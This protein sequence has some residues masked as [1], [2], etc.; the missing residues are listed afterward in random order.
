MSQIY[1]RGDGGQIA[2]YQAGNRVAA[3]SLPHRRL[4]QTAVQ[5]RDCLEGLTSVLYQGRIYFAYCNLAHQVAMDAVG[6]GRE[7]IVLTEHQEESRF[8]GLILTVR[9]EQ[10]ML[11][12]QAWNP[13]REQF[14]L[15]LTAP[16]RSA[17]SRRVGDMGDAPGRC[18]LL[19]WQGE[20]FLLAEPENGENGRVFLWRSLWEWQ[21]I[22]WR[23]R[24]PMAQQ[25]ERE[26]FLQRR[27][28]ALEERESEQR[29]REAALRERELELQGR[30]AALGERESELQGREAALQEQ[31]AA[32]REPRQEYR[33]RLEELR[34]KYEAQ[35]DSARAQ[36]QDLADT[37]AQL[38]QIG[39]MWRDK[40][41]QMEG[42]ER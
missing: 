25:A 24:G 34:R 20:T 13:E 6:G 22:P 31:E 8:C 39:K 30:E 42:R 3:V 12:Y 17:P 2:L 21:E 38:Q 27:A 5:K 33:E 10:L 29:G 16:Y 9:E 28:A 35:L 32:L 1:P 14:E 36:Y 37:A 11:L 26:I 15:R 7:R 23:K 4:G 19:E 18:R 40:C 41:Y